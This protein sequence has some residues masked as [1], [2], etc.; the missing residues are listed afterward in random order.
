ME[1]LRDI[2]EN[3]KKKIVKLNGERICNQTSNRCGCC[4]GDYA[5]ISLKEKIEIL[6]FVKSNSGVKEKVLKN[7]LEESPCYF[8]DKENG[9]CLIYDL[10]PICCR[11][12]SYKIYE[13]DDCYKTCSP[14]EPCK[15]GKS[16][17]I[18]IEKNR[19]FTKEIPLKSF[20]LDDEE[21]YFIDDNIISEYQEYKKTQNLRLSS[22][23]DEIEK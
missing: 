8:R 11:Y 10:R 1:K 20:F 19:V 18:K 9:V 6:K 5:L 17:V 16:T 3:A 23:I 12:I 22:I 21:Y 4:S 15:K 2:L 14:F 13:K 7:K